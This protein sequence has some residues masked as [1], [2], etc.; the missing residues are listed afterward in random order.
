[1]N[2]EEGHEEYSDLREECPGEAKLSIEESAVTG[3]T[4]N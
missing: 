2:E 1:M 3:M 4:G